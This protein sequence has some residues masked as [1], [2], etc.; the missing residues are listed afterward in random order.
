MGSTLP[1]AGPEGREPFGELLQEYRV[2]LIQII[3]Y[4]V[5]GGVVLLMGL[6][7]F[8]LL[9]QGRGRGKQGYFVV[10]AALC[11]GAWYL[12]RQAYLRGRFRVLVCRDAIVRRQGRQV[13]ALPWRE[14]ATVAWVQNPR[15]DAFEAA[16]ILIVES[17]SGGMP[18]R[19]DGSLARLDAL[20]QAVEERTLPHLLP[21]ALEAYRAGETLTF[22]K[23]GIT[24]A[25]LHLAGRTLPWEEVREVRRG[26]DVIAVYALSGERPVEQ[27]GVALVPNAHV[28]LALAE[29][30]RR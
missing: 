21:A 25:G 24:R 12:F 16:H 27:V 19:F 26:R 10:C 8:W 9:L 22:G 15:R 18:L 28:L 6:L 3:L 23:L 11:S 30:A 7:G 13:D 1:G 2:R 17:A 4:P 29:Q 5:I 20:R 14:V